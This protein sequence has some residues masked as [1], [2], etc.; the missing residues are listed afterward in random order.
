M[1]E[2]QETETLKIIKDQALITNSHPR[3]SQLDYLNQVDRLHS[4][5]SQ[6]K[7]LL[8]EVSLQDKMHKK[9]EAMLQ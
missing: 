8:M 4:Y 7:S 2:K 3:D 9:D 1:L 6:G 5:Q